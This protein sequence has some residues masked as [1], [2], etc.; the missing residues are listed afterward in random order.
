[1][2]KLVDK[3]LELS[4]SSFVGVEKGESVDGIDKEMKKLKEQFSEADWDELIHSV[5]VFMRPMLAEQKKKH[6][7][8]N[9]Q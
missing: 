9:K 7:K 4:K 1:M 3:Y 8:N 5:P 6:L 2:S